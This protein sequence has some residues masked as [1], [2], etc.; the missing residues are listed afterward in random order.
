MNTAELIAMITKILGQGFLPDL[1]LHP[2]VFFGVPLAQRIKPG[3]H[4]LRPG[5]RVAAER[6]KHAVLCFKP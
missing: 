6:L 3:R 5:G 4:R 2:R 1:V